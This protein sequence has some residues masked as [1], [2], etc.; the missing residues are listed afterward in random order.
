MEA[1][2]VASIASRKSLAVS[3]ALRAG[4]FAVC[5]VSHAKHPHLL[6]RLFSR[7]AL[8]EV[9]RESNAWPKAVARF[10]A[11]WGACVV[12]PVDFADVI[13]FSRFEEV[14]E[15]IGVALAAPSYE[16]AIAASSKSLLPELLKSVAE[17]PR[18]AVVES[19]EGASKLQALSPPLVVKGLSDASKPEFFPTREQAAE[20]AAERAPCLVQEY[21]PG[22]GRGYYAVAHEGEPLIEFTHERIVEY[23]PAGGASLAARG[24][25]RD[26]RLYAL[27]RRVVAQLRWTGP[28]MVETRFVLDE[29]RYLVV[30]VNPKLWGSL[31]LPVHLGYSFPLILALAAVKGPSAARR[32]AAGLSV[33]SGQFG[34]VLDGMRYLAKAPSTWFKLV[35]VGARAS[36]FDASDPARVLAQLLWALERLPR[37][38]AQWRESISADLRKL[39]WW[40]RKLVCEGVS[41]VIFDLD[42]TLVELPLNWRTVKAELVREG[43]AKPWEGVTEALRR[44]WREDRG[45]Y[46]KASKL[47]EELEV[48]A[49][50]RARPIV[51]P[52]ALSGLRFTVITLQ[53]SPAAVESLSRAGFQPAARTIGRDAYG[54]CKE[55]AFKRV[56]RPAAVFEDNLA[57]AVRAL[58]A[59]HLPVFTARDEYRLARGVRLGI[60]SLHHSDVPKLLTLLTSFIR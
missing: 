46:E 33:R 20:R 7:K 1:A 5:G 30:E 43:L 3:K 15:R 38:R 14:F 6:S 36:D 31:D 35:R 4:G 9:G 55:E 24:P 12:I 16:A 58:K 59:G 47:V 28:I 23:D 17:V 44:L 48:E 42:G 10:A 8:V 18:Q 41:E 53:A 26:P 56:G 2:L 52:S 34:W 19:R 39:G 32:A 60:P 21:V 11:E 29:G 27:G 49:S 51:S 40:L 50:R 45:L 57:N 54:P 13:A 37:E 25:V 22:V